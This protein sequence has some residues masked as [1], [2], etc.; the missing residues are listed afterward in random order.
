MLANFAQLHNPRP[1]TA[2][3]TIK[4]I[5]SRIAAIDERGCASTVIGGR[6]EYFRSLEDLGEFVQLYDSGKHDKAIPFICP[7]ANLVIYG[8]LVCRAPQW[9]KDEARDQGI[10]EWNYVWYFTFAREC[11]TAHI[12][13]EK[14][15]DVMLEL[16][17]LI[18][19]EGADD[20]VMPF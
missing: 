9:V 14:Y 20:S 8:S 2:P 4:K 15:D 6:F 3:A 7:G 16:A 12:V 17:E 18:R 10:G 11:E 19:I 13:A 1:K 5:G